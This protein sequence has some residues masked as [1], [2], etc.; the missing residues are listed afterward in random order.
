[1][2]RIVPVGAYSSAYK[3]VFADCEDKCD[4]E[5]ALVG[6]WWAL[7]NNAEDFPIVTGYKSLRIAKT[8]RVRTLAPLRVIFRIN[9]D[10]VELKW[11]ECVDDVE[12]RGPPLM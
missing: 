4:L 11:I 12:F 6:V 8:D 9:G 5:D 1:M 3:A 10:A 2:R 7:S